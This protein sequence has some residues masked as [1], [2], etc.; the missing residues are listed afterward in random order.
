MA[1]LSGVNSNILLRTFNSCTRACLDYGA[2]CFNMFNLTQMRRLQRKQNNG[3]KLV[4]G[5]N[6]WAPTSNI[7]AELRILPIANRAEVFQANMI[8]K[9][10]IN[11][12]HPLH[13]QVADELQYPRPRNVKP[14]LTWLTSICRSHRKLSP[15]IPGAEM[16]TQLPPWS[17]P[18]LI[19]IIIII[20]V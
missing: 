20:F 14:K 1:S 7:H 19:I 10:M 5:V 6:K 16:T 12:N 13:E 3:L 4:L 17:Q 18:P 15:N 9:I 11:Q 8:N 2:E